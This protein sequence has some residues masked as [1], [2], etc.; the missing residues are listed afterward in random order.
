MDRRAFFA[1][2]GKATLGL[3][4][5]GSLSRPRQASAVPP[6]AT[7]AA[8]KVGA[9]TKSFQDRSIPE[10][11]RI[12]KE[13]GLDGLDLTV[14][15]GGHI[16]PKDVETELPK[17]VQAATDAGVAILFLTTNITDPSPEAERVL[18]AAAAQ[19]IRRVKLGYYNY[20][21]KQFGTLKKQLVDVRD[22]VAKVAR[23]ARK[24]NVLP[25]IHIHADAMIPSHGTLL[26]ELIRDFSP[27]EVG[28]Y[29]DT[30]HMVKEGGGEGWRQGLDLLAPWI[31]LCSVKNFVW[32]KTDRDKH[33]QQQWR[34][35]NVPVA[36]GISPIPEFI[37]ALKQLNFRGAYSLH[38]EYKG[39]GSWQDLDTDGCIRQTAEDFAFFKTLL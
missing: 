26:Y 9:F 37:A 31:A 19:G 34:T 29:V 21:V 33:G 23:M 32:T 17:A 12:F 35:V 4:L 20:D 10:V 27:D 14:R 28:A 8:S 11:C 25:C 18:A 39:K 24:H 36:D 16:D 5:A 15:R 22:R 1:Y 6:D 3:A 13:M 38:S 2:S 30:L 7:A